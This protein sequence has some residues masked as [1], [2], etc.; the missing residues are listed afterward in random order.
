MIF[1]AL[2]S[3]GD[4]QSGELLAKGLTKGGTGSTGLIMNTQKERYM[5]ISEGVAAFEATMSISKPQL[6]TIAKQTLSFVLM[7]K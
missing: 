7:P 1:K 4:S 6:V 5:E 3:L 2:I